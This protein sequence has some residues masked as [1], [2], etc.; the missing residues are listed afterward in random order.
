[1]NSKLKTKKRWSSAGAADKILTNNSV[2]WN[3][4]SEMN[5]QLYVINQSAE[6]TTCFS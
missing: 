4:K 3:S 2:K 5:A 6:P 1:M